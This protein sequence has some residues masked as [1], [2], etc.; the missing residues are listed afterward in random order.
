M[1]PC[2]QSA[3]ARLELADAE[4]DAAERVFQTQALQTTDVGRRVRAA[5]RRERGRLHPRRRRLRATA[6]ARATLRFARSLAR[7][8]EAQYAQTR[9]S[10][11]R[12][13]VDQ[14]IDG[15]MHGVYI[16][17][18]RDPGAFQPPPGVAVRPDAAEASLPVG[19][20]SALSAP[21]TDLDRFL[22]EEASLL[23]YHGYWAMHVR[24]SHLRPGVATASP[25]WRE[26]AHLSP[27]TTAHLQDLL[28]RGSRRRRMSRL[29]WNLAAALQG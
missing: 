16:P 22:P 7:S 25:A 21:R 6:V 14:L 27:H 19:F 29:P 11:A 1:K 18:D 9:A 4:L 26:F 5:R 24:L 13:F 15:K 23:M 3:P 20:A 17:I 28:A 10:R 8:Q 2:R 12:W